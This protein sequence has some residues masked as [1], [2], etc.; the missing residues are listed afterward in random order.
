MF[1]TATLD[2][3]TNT[4]DWPR[5]STELLNQYALAPAANVGDVFDRLLVLD[6]GIR[7]LTS[8]TRL[9]GTA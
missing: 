8:Q 7:C 1:I 3:I 5:H 9:V 6:S 4:K 2:N